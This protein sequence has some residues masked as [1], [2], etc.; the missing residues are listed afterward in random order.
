MGNRSEQMKIQ[1]VCDKCKEQYLIDIEELNKKGYFI[2]GCGF[3]YK[4]H[5]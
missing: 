1:I 5:D 3:K 4:I 2:C